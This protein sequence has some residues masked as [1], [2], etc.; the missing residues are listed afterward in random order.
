MAVSIL[1]VKAGNVWEHGKHRSGVPGTLFASLR[2]LW[3][4]DVKVQVFSKQWIL[5][6]RKLA[7]GRLLDR[8]E[9]E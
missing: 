3:E 5:Q 9:R 1:Q 7:L 6:G 2:G 8:T 4:G